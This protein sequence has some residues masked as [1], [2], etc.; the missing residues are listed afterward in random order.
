MKQHLFAIED[1]VLKSFGPPF[2]QANDLVA[3]RTCKNLISDP[4]SQISKSP[5]DFNLWFLGV[6]DDELGEIT[7]NKDCLLNLN[8]LKDPS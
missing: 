2:A 8:S 7:F 1:T 6:Y 3:K 5:G 4:A